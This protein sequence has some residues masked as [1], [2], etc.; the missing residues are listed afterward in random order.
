[1]VRNHVRYQVAGNPHQ[2]RPPVKFHN[3][4]TIRTAPGWIKTRIS[5]FVG[6]RRFYEMRC[7]R[8]ATQPVLDHLAEIVARHRAKYPTGGLES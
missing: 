1:M 3:Y 4:W 6:G 2:P 5:L 7:R 8:S